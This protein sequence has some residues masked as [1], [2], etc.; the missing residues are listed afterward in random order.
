[1]P[2]S[3]RIR[4][5][6]KALRAPDEFH[7]LG[8]KGLDWARANQTLLTAIG[9]G[10]VGIA[11]LALGFGWY[12]ARQAEA[13][14]VRFQAAHTEFAGAKFTE[15]A[16]SFAGLGRDYGSTPFGRL[17]GLYRAHALSRQ[18]SAGPAATAY[19]EYLAT[20]PPADYLRQEALVGLGRSREAA[21]EGVAAMEAYTEAA[22]IDGPLRTDARLALARMKEAAGQTSE[23]QE[24][25]VA[26]LKEEPDGSLRTLLEAKVPPGTAP[27]APVE[28]APATP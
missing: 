13:A 25:Y 12:R 9:A 16:E 19:S 1:M 23:A 5:D 8:A 22:A 7:T 21:G 15:A 14:A 6:R 18:G 26:L 3:E 24:I 20:S 10:A 17:A 27:A 2:P 28:A 11:I 4:I